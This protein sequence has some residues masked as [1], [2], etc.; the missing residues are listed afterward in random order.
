MG[1][2]EIGDPRKIVGDPGKYATWKSEISLH[3]LLKKINPKVPGGCYCH[4]DQKQ[5]EENLFN[6]TG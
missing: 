3:Y 5:I 6:M 1:P 2:G 4:P